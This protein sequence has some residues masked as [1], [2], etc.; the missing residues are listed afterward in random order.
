[1]SKWPMIELNAFV[2]AHKLSCKSRSFGGGSKI[3]PLFYGLSV[4][5]LEDIDRRRKWLRQWETLA[6]EDQ[7]KRI[8]VN[9]WKSALE[10]L[11]SFN[12]LDY[13]RV[14]KEITAYEMKIVSV[15]CESIV[16]DIKWDDSHVQGKSRICKVFNMSISSLVMD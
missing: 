11:G 6:K 5:D 16:P 10:I 9:E 13:D 15:V 4:S 7:K 14:L 1:M 3:L 2:R 12:G 8:V